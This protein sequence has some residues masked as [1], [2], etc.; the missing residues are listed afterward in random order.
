MQTCAGWSVMAYR[1]AW[2]LHKKTRK[3][4]ARFNFTCP[5]FRALEQKPH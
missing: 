1:C 4:N 2:P 3:T 5:N